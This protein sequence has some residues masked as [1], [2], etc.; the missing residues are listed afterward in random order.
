MTKLSDSQPKAARGT[1]LQSRSIQRYDRK[2]PRPQ[3]KMK[4]VPRSGA[5]RSSGSKIAKVVEMLRKP[6]GA[7]IKALMVTTGWQAHSVRGAISG[8]IKKKLGLTVTSVRVNDTRVYRIA[9]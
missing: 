4:A 5:A 6:S 7:S 8:T 3:A 2:T 1:D 9:K